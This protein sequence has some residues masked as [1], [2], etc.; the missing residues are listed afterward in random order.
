MKKSVRIWLICMIAD[1]ALTLT[2]PPLPMVIFSAV[3]APNVSRKNRIVT[4]QKI[5]L[6]SW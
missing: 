5:G 1:G 6:R 2:L 4:T 3:T